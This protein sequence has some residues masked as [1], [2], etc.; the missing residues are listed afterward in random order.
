MKTAASTLLTLSLLLGG[1]SV[2]CDRTV[3][4]TE[5]VE[6]NRDGSTET[7]KEETTVSPDG[8]TETKKETEKTPPTN[9]QP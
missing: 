2:G 8:T 4:K 6:T 5:T 3:K 7:K 9:P 1:A